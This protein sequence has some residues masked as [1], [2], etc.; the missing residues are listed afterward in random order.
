LPILESVAI[1]RR[2]A[3][4]C[5]HPVRKAYPPLA[6]RVE[7]RDSSKNVLFLGILSTLMIP[8]AVVMVPQF[9]IWNLYMAAALIIVLPCLVLFFFSQNAFLQG[10]TITDIKR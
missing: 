4:R 1:D 5:L 3:F 7:Q 8:F 10:I 6:N 2:S 9:I